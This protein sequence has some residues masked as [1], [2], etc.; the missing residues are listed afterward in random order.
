M[1]EIV[2]LVIVLMLSLYG[3]VEL[4][5]WVAVHMLSPAEGCSGVLVIPVSGHR[6]DIENIVRS[7]AA[8]KRWQTPPATRQV[9]LLDT[10]MDDE[11]RQLAE[12]VCGEVG[13]VGLFQPA[14]LDGILR[15]GLQ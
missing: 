12:R 14:D 11:T 4:I 13:G 3:C 1:G 5:R 9:L 2:L 6:D 8:R 15:D 7:A 10:G